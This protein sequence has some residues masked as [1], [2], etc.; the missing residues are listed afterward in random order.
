M[1]FVEY[2][3]KDIGKIRSGKRLKKGKKA[4]RTAKP[5]SGTEN[6]MPNKNKAPKKRK[7]HIG[8]MIVLLHP[9]TAPRSMASPHLIFPFFSPSNSVS[10]KRQKDRKK[11]RS[12]ML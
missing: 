2:K 11:K 12:K 5:I 4:S 8:G 9:N 1:N 7:N 10:E 6:K 3:Y